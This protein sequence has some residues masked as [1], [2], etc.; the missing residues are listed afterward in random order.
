MCLFCPFS[1]TSL[2]RGVCGHVYVDRVSP[3]IPTQ[4]MSEL[5]RQRE[6]CFH[7]YTSEA[8]LQNLI[9]CIFDHRWL[10]NHL[11]IQLEK[12]LVLFYLLR[13]IREQ[14]YSMSFY[15]YSLFFYIY[16]YFVFERLLK[17]FWLFFV[18]CYAIYTF[19][20]VIFCGEFTVLFSKCNL[21]PKSE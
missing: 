18:Y 17:L 10:C 4:F 6:D 2:M 7:G 20:C 14:T 1:T 19:Q 21:F 5:G 8:D 15:F 3:I 9:E 13:H 12:V 16:F 11:F